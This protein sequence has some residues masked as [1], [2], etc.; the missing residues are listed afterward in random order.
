M[1]RRLPLSLAS[2]VVLGLWAAAC[3]EE[4]APSNQVPVLTGPFVQTSDVTSGTPVALMLEATDADGDALTYE[5]VQTPPTPAGTFSSPSIPNPTW[6]APQVTTATSF[7]LGITVSDGKEGTARRSV[8][9]LVRPQPPANRVPVVTTGT[10]TATPSAVTGSVPVQLA[11]SASDPDGDAL[12]YSWSQEPATPVGSFSS[13]FVASPSWIS[14]VVTTSTPFTLKVTI[15]DGQGGSVQGQV[16]VTVAPPSTTNRLPTLTAGPSSSASSINGQQSVNLSVSASDPDADTLTYSWSQ[17]PSSPAG[18][19]S[20]TSAQNPSWTAP[21]VTTDTAFQL[22]VTVT[23]GKGGSVN[24]SVTVTVRAPVNRAPTISQAAQANPTSVTGSV[25]VQLSVSATDPDGDTLT[26][27]WAQTPTSPAGSFTNTSVANPSW[28]APVV[29]STTVFTL[30]VSISDGRGGS[31]QSQVNVSVAPPIPQNNPPTVNTPT[32]NPTTL[33]YQQSTTLAVTASDADGDPLTYAWTQTAPASP[34]GTFSSTTVAGPT[35]TAPRVATNTAFQLRV[36]VSDGR[37]GSNSGTASVTVNAF[38]NS[39]PTLTS[40]PSASATTV[41]EQE[42]ITLSVSASDADGDPLT[43]AW[44]QTA[45]ASPV[46]TF[47]STTSANPTWT[48]PDVTANGTYTLRVTV[49]DGQGGSVQGSIDITVQKVNQPPTVAATITGPSTL[50]AGNTGSFSITASDPDGDPLTYSWDQTDPAT[51]GTWVGSRTGSSA[52][53]YSPAVGAQTSFTLSV[54]VTDGQSTP[55]VRTVTFPVTV[56]NYSTDV[57]AVWSSG[58]CTGCHGTQG[59]LNLG[60]ADSSNLVNVPAAGSCNPTL[61]VLPGDPDNSALILKMEGT[62]C[63][64]G[65]R[66]PQGNPSYFD[67]NRGLVI[68]VRSWILA[69]APGP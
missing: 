7:Q 57:R 33:N 49:S 23:D 65:N 40:G 30:R 18:A 66:M 26:Y 52:Q 58:G 8:T 17:S 20:S 61:R 67:N 50:L 37:G 42:A 5:W 11:L 46:G 53:W 29:S 34:L 47:S 28:T 31:V 25:P 13:L 3:G 16:N 55:V 62:A 15:S 1:H 22:R 36:T 59:S 56:P 38:V 60:A 2:F 35:W 27:T 68:R 39:Q 19:F 44:A 6:T 45:P 48:A 43:Y 41:N 51:L 63:G 54:S 14:P 69:G 64:S 24:G 4:P 9:V 10:P 32:A 12:T 21:A